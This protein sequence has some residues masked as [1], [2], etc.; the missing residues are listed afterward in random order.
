MGSQ[1]KLL[2]HEGKHGDNYILFQPGVDEG[3]AWLAMFR[4]FDEW[5]NLYDGIDDPDSREDL[6]HRKLYRGAKK[7]NMEYARRLLQERNG[8]EY[9]T[10]YVENVDTPANLLRNLNNG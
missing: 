6:R 10:V 1:M 4:L 8:G 7:G 2:V 9:E 5:E 3:E